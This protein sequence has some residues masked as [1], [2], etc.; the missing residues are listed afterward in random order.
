MLS[1]LSNH[2]SDRDMPHA[3]FNTGVTALSSLTGQ[4][5]VGLSLL[6][7]VALPGLLNNVKLE[8]GYARLLWYGL[9]IY[10]ILNHNS[11]PRSE[12]TSFHESVQKYLKCFFDVA[13]P[14]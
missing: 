1:R 13:G 11:F 7:I 12:L 4:E 6:T 14:Q 3:M 10:A 2:Q 9:S 5:Y 8:K